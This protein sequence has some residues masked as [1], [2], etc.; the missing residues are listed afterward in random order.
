[1]KPSAETMQMRRLVGKVALLL[2]FVYLLV[3]FGGLVTLAQG[4]SGPAITWPLL[5]VPAAAFVPAVIFAIQLHR[6][7]D[8]D[9]TRAL[10]RQCALYTVIGLALLIADAV[11]L[12]QVNAS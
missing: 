6:T 11:I 12:S 10:W 3:L 9:R 1:V 5:I 7:S 4:Q 2:A 8:P